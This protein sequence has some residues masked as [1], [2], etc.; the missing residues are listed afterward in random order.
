MDFLTFKLSFFCSFWLHRRDW[1]GYWSVQGIRQARLCHHACASTLKEM[2]T[3]ILSRYAYLPLDARWECTGPAG[4]TEVIDSYNKKYNSSVRS[5]LLV[6][7]LMSTAL[8]LRCR[9][10]AR[11]VGANEGRSR[12]CQSVEKADHIS[13]PSRLVGCMAN[14]RCSSVWIFWLAR[15]HCSLCIGTK[16]ADEAWYKPQCQKCLRVGVRLYISRLHNY[17]GDWPKFSSDIYWPWAAAHQIHVMQKSL[18]TRETKTEQEAAARVGAPS[19][20]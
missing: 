2:A 8:S 11:N 5:C 18:E 19:Q 3:T 10:G 4:Q 7:Q 20:R 9:N 12:E 17:A 13:C 1:V 6:M 15:I 16:N 14:T